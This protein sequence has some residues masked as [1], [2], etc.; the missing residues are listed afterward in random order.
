MLVAA[1]RKYLNEVL[2]IPTPQEKP[3]AQASGLPYFLQDA[4]QFVELELLGRPVVLAISPSNQKQALGDIRIRLDKVREQGKQPVVFVTD[5]LAS[6]ER[7]RLIE[8]KVPFIVPGNQLYLPDLGL[9]LREHFRQR[10]P[11]SGAA[12]SPSTQAILISALMN[13]PL[14]NDWR[15][16]RLASDMGYTPMTLSRAVR[17][18]N[19]AGLAATRRMGRSQ[20]LHRE[21]PPQEIWEMARPLLRSP[22]RRTLWAVRETL[23]PGRQWRLAGLSALARDSMLT[24]P[25]QPVCAITFAEWREALKAGA[26]EAP[27]PSDAAQELELW[28][29]DPA[30]VPGRGTVDPLS[31]TLSLQDS[32]DERVL[33]ALD[34]LKGQLPW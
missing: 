24:E 31:L 6:Y 13:E 17:E 29:Y 18:L 1:T 15:P 5:A 25:R 8:Q 28:I 19:A 32:M 23:P 9:D 33:Q 7:K 21:L 11:S 27:E 22:V 26:R 10:P 2:G 34:E 16:A 30:L 20:W 4:F 3:W 12:L 14:A